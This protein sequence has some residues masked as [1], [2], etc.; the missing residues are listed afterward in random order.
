MSRVTG[1]AH[2]ALGMSALLFVG[3]ALGYARGKSIPSLVAGTAFGTGYAISGWLISKGDGKEGHSLALALSGTLTGV[4]GGRFLK[5]KKVMPAGVLLGAG[6]L[7]ATYH[8]IKA[9]EW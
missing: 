3:G 6:G 2:A 8:G 5:T 4:M 7:S 9:A 1:E